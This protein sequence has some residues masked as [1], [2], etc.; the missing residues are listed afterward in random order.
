[1]RNTLQPFRF[2][3]RPGAMEF[4]AHLRFGWYPQTWNVALMRID[5]TADGRIFLHFAMLGAEDEWIAVCCSL[6]SVRVLPE[7]DSEED[8]PPQ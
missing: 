3:F 5:T 1:M 7:S 4:P 2:L 6:V 8:D